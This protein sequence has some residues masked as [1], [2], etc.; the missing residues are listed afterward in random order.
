M[1]VITGENCEDFKGGMGEGGMFATKFCLRITIWSEVLRVVVLVPPQS[2]RQLFDHYIWRSLRHPCWIRTSCKGVYWK[3]REYLR[4]LYH[5]VLKEEGRFTRSFIKIVSILLLLTELSQDLVLWKL[6]STEVFA[7]WIICEVLI[8]TRSG[9]GPSRIII[10]Q[11][12]GL[13]LC[14]LLPTKSKIVFTFNPPSKW[15]YSILSHAQ[16]LG[17]ELVETDDFFLVNEDQPKV[18]SRSTEWMYQERTRP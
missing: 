2:V 3:R 13:V 14:E 5:V 1:I 6:R 18:W 8:N 16:W 10:D 15:E 11:R 12:K 17:L 4:T 7:T 9:P